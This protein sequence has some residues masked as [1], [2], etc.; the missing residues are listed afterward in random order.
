M[1]II[2]SAA[3]KSNEYNTHGFFAFFNLD[4][5]DGE[6]ACSCVNFLDKIYV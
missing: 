3:P 6:I 1:I 5:D 4:D 2:I